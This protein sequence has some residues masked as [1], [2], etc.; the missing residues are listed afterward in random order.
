MT[1]VDYIV[2]PIEINYSGIVNIKE[3]YELIRLW[4]ND[5]GFFTMEKESE[6]S[7]DENGSNFATKFEASKKV[8]EYTKY[9]IEIKIKAKSLKETSEQNAYQGEYNVSFESYLEKD[10]E[11]RNENKPILKIL[12][13]LYEKLV[14]RNRL[15][16]YESE[17][18]ELTNAVYNEVKAFLN[19]AKFN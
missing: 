3:L 14:E 5:K 1:E 6:G 18:M 17:L 2:K 7:E 15:S 19:L 13:G 9:M 10:Y 12:K 8:E 4:F 16:K 11:D